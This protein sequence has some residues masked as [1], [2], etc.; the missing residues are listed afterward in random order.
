MLEGYFGRVR[1]VQGGHPGRGY[2]KMWKS[3]RTVAL[4]AATTWPLPGLRV[5]TGSYWE[6]APEVISSRKYMLGTLGATPGTRVK[7]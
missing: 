6:I 2:W 4:S 5:K 1:M 3:E 7:G